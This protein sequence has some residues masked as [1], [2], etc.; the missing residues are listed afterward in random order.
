MVGKDLPASAVDGY[1]PP[2]PLE[3]LLAGAIDAERDPNPGLRLGRELHYTS[4]HLPGHLMAASATLE[5]ALDAWF[6]YQELVVPELE[7]RLSRGEHHCALTVDASGPSDSA[8]DPDGSLDRDDLLVAALVAVGRSLLGGRLP[9]HRALLRRPV[10]ATLSDHERFFDCPVRFGAARNGI[11]FSPALLGQP[12]P[13]ARPRYRRHLEHRAGLLLARR[14]REGGI[15]ARVRA[16]LRAGLGHGAVTVER[17]AED[18]GMTPRTLQRRLR[19]EGIQFARLRDQVRMKCACQHLL[20]DGCDMQALALYLGFSDTANFY[21]AF[22]RWK[23]CA[24]G[25]YR[26]RALAS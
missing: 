6:R 17:V 8:T 7:F 25:E 26:R 16:R 19:D 1:S 18:L 2:G 23:G 3:R 9:I 14:Q 21:H 12:L 5:Q 13:G 24:P 15:V 11:E 10:P 4:L 22:K 20:A